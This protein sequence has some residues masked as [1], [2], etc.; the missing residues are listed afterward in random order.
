MVSPVSH[1]HSSS[2]TSVVAFRNSPSCGL[3][4][5]ERLL[6]LVIYTQSNR[7]DAAETSVELNFEQLEKLREDVK[8]AIEEAREAKEDEGFWSD[9]ADFFGGDLASLATAIAAVAAVVA[10]GGAAA[11]VLAVVASAA[12]FA[13]DHAEELGIPPEIAMGIALGASVAGLCCGDAKG[14]LDFGKKVTDFAK[15]V[16][17]YASVG[18]GL[19]RGAGAGLTAVAGQYEGDAIDYQAD[20]RKAEG[21]Q[22]LVSVDIDEA[23]A[24]LASSLG[25]QLGVAEQAS[26]I[27]QGTS[28]SSSVIL[29]NFAGAA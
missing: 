16:K 7:R 24:E 2:V 15:N 3:S 26:Q 22:E 27:Q 13:A 29:N 21:R 25:R 18:A 11:A 12:S 10:T 23:L 9:L 6:A 5:E 1:A 14:L 17:L 20:A 19:A 4:G 28:A 8:K